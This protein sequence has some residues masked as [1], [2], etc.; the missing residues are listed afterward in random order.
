[1]SSHAISNT[2]E[3]RDFHGFGGDKFAGGR[4][5]NGQKR[6]GSARFVDQNS[7]LMKPF[8]MTNDMT[9]GITRSR[10]MT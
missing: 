3:S 1:M 7:H 4:R 8:P 5:S 10:P 2:R 6:L 9:T